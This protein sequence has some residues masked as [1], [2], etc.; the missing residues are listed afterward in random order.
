[1]YTIGEFSKITKITVKAL[2]FYHEKELLTPS[3]ID[4]E[5][6]YRYYSKGDIE[7][8][9]IIVNL[10]SFGFSLQEIQSITK[11]FDD[12]SDVTQILQKQ[13]DAI[14][15]DV[16]KLTAISSTLELIL[17]KEKE[18][19]QMTDVFD[20]IQVKRLPELQ[21]VYVRWQGKYS[22]TGKA[23]GQV[24]RAAGRHAGGAALNLYFDCEYKENTEIE[25]CL[26]IK[27]KITTK[28]ECKALPA[29]EFVTLVHVGSYENI[30]SSYEKIFDYIKSINKKTLL[31]S[32]EVYLKGPGMIFKGNPDKY[33]TEIQIQIEES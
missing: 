11:E 12:E 4:S 20:D 24:Y 30:G 13:K 25:S 15:R 23:M 3:Y 22:E 7:T 8:A 16:K 9:Q 28:L 10:K 17:M 14:E 18:V 1:M 19:A 29:G 32:R 21:V 6:N 2:R 26:P 33:L 31:P 27:K 5:S